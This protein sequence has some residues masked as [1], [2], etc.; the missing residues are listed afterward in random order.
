CMRKDVDERYQDYEPLIVDLKRLRLQCTSRERGSIIGGDG[1][2]AHG[3]SGSLSLPPP[4]GIA[5]PR[6]GGALR[7]AN[8]R[9]GPAIVIEQYDAAQTHKF[10]NPL[11]ISAV[12]ILVLLVAGVTIAVITS[13]SS[14][15]AKKSPQS[16]PAIAVLLDKA[17]ER[18]SSARE[19][20]DNAAAYRAYKDTVDILH[21]LQEGVTNFEIDKQALPGSLSDIANENSVR[22]NFSVDAGNNPLDAWNTPIAYRVIEKEIRSAGLDGTLDNSDDIIISFE[23]KTQI[24]PE[25]EKL[26]AKS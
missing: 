1:T 20:N 9:S 12:V 22:M 2:A 4:P 14:G 7:S 18:N 23:G 13:S 25:Y 21:S 3:A 26:K 11:T 8:S 5:D 16:T 17:A 6:G 19:N 15:N 24:P 10:W